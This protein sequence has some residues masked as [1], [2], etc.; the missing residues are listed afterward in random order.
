MR[1]LLGTL[2]GVA[3]A[4][5]I[6][7]AIEYV[8]G[9][10]YP[11]PTDID[12]GDSAAMAQLIPSLPFPAKLIVVSAWLLGAL[13]G[14][15]SAMRITDWRWSAV[16]VTLFVIAGGVINFIDL[17]HPFWMQVCAVVLPP[18]GGWLAVRLHARPYPG[19]ALLG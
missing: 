4:I 10:L 16:V 12:P 3:I 7:M 13:G 14:A 8:D 5:L 17:P 9:Q 19:E 15:W 6:M 2:A 1:Y 11:W 18:I